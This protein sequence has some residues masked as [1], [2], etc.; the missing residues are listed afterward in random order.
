[1]SKSDQK[2]LSKCQNLTNTFDHSCDSR[3][4]RNLSTQFLIITI[5]GGGSGSVC[6]CV[7]GGKWHE[8]S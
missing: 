5:M 4:L 2:R 7:G 6:V 3:G 8:I 1:M